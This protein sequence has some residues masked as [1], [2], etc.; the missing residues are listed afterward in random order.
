[1]KR[2]LGIAIAIGLA[3]IAVSLPAFR[4]DRYRERIHQTLEQTLQR[5]V[6]ILGKVTYSVWNGPGFSIG[7][8]VIH[9]DPAA[10]LEPFAY[11]TSLDATVNPFAMLRGKWEIST[12]VL[13]EPR[14]NLTKLDTGSWNVRPLLVR[15]TSGIA[16]NPPEI[17]VRSGRINLKFGE[18]KSVLYF[19]NTDFDLSSSDAGL[20]L[21]FTAEPTRTDRPAQ[22]FG[23][24]QGSG[25]YHPVANKP[26]QLD[27]DLELTRSALSEIVTLLEGRGAG[28]RG[29]L[30]SRAKIQGPLNDLKI[31]GSARLEEIQ[32]WDLLRAGSGDWPVRY[33]GR[34][35]FPGGELD[36]VTQSEGDA[37]P[38]NFRLRAHRLLENASWGA[39]TQFN[40]MPVSA[41]REI[42]QYLNVALPE[43][44]TVEGKLSGVLGYS[45]NHGLQGIVDL[46]VASVKG[47]DLTFRLEQARLLVDRELFQ[48]E[49]AMLTMGEGRTLEVQGSYQPGSQS[50]TWRTGNQSLPAAD[51]LLS[52]Q[53][54]TGLNAPFLAAMSEGAFRG[55]LNYRKDGDDPPQWSGQF[56]IKDASFVLPGLAS[57][58]AIASARAVMAE[59]RISLESIKGS[60]AGIEFE[61]SFHQTG[62]SRPNRLRLAIGTA[63]VGAIEKLMLP[64]LK[65]DGGLLG[66]LSLRATPIPDWLR[67]RR[68]D[69]SVEIDELRM[70]EAWL[71]GLDA[72]FLWTG[73]QVEM[74]RVHWER[75]ETSAT[76]SVVLR[77]ARSE[78]EYRLIGEVKDL[79]W[80]GGTMDAEATLQ[81]S[82]TGALLLRNIKGSGKFAGKG[83]TF[84]PEGDFP[85]VAG[86]FD[87]S[88]PR[89]T[90]SLKLTAI[91]V[92]NGLDSYTGQGSSESD[93]RVYVD[94][95]NARK[96]MRMV[97]T[98]WPFQLELAQ[99]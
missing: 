44:V 69:A 83:F 13:N 86:A 98:L 70:G 54:L 15:T 7:E 75:D 10:G 96:K 22:G 59:N 26:S 77:L 38:V 67:T 82:G 19:A 60:A 57:T 41:L 93:G 76:G 3:A 49:P 88:A 90:P 81:T 42:L 46:P 91:E 24:L 35:D 95:V 1:M 56:N 8:V 31:D 36:L 16:G 61:G 85:T 45:P 6:D 29:F 25:R 27:L 73:T 39:I 20:R 66:R 62:L 37:A 2:R 17:R 4:A 50:F 48:L 47:A 79:E 30:A 11:V 43:R 55:T 34:L 72:R 33:R 9:E 68:L 65:R 71:G 58:V 92:S 40:Q 74:S 32:R 52:Q 12:I 18:T 94:L 21:S 63:D 51:F 53:Q 14:V 97:G 5:R 64:S 87:F 23:T 84:E 28:M 78:P 80:K 89:G 99:K